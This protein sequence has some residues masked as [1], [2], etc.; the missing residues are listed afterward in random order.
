MNHPTRHS[1]IKY[2]SIKYML[3]GST[4]VA[5]MG[6]IIEP[7]TLMAKFA[8]TS[9][10][11]QQVVQPQAVLSRDR[12]SQLLQL[13][14]QTPKDQVQQVIQ[15]PYCQLANRKP[16]DGSPIRQDAYPLAFDPHTWLIVTYNGD[17]Y[18]DYS[19]SFRR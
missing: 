16:A 10:A 5:A 14:Q 18:S 7:Q 12:L 2:S 15:Q 13:P 11:C 6:L 17:T 1:S 8:P 3:A 19:F 9:A 4:V